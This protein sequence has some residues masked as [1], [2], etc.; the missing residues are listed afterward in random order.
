[1]PTIARHITG[2]LLRALEAN[3]AVYLGGP[4]Q[5]GKTTLVEAM[6]RNEFPAEYVTLDNP[7]QMAAA[8][9]SPE[10]FLAGRGGSLVIDEV[11]L[12]P[13]LFRPLKLVVDEARRTRGAGANGLFILTGSAGVMA[14]PGL[15]DAMV[16]RMGVLALHPLSG[17]E[18]AGGAGDFVERLFRGDFEAGGDGLAPAGLIRAATFPGVSGADDDRRSEWFDGYIATVMQRDVRMLAEI[19]KLGAIPNLLRILAAR[20]GGLVNDADIARDASLNHVTCRNYKTL[21]KMLFLVFEVAPWHRNIGK[22]LVK[23]PK[24]YLTDTLMMCHLLG[25]GLPELEASRPELFGRVLENF[26]AAELLKLASLHGGGLELLHFRTGDGKEVDFVLEKPGGEVAAV[27]VKARDHVSMADF[28]GIGEL[29]RAAGGDFACGVVLY[30][31]S[32]VVPFGE[33]LWAV[34]LGNLWK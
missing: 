22:R 18:A 23:S 28:T 2:R 14:L 33:N 25:Y 32:E 19:E 16:G 30:R 15:S 1:M 7:T 9:A 34:P 6:S 20:A 3:P 26:V 11:Q 29:Q 17:A 27:E 8:S 12:V 31:G 21:L 13:E 10:S 24:G 5:A 4:R